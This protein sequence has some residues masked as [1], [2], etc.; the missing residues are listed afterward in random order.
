V[1]QHDHPYLAQFSGGQQRVAIARALA[2]EPIVMRFDES[3]S[4]LDSEMVGE[5]LDVMQELARAGMT[6]SVVT[7][8]MGFARR[9]ARRIASVESSHIELSV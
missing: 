9:A 4:A 6:T 3:T 2:M 8:D 7:H 5:V 1:P